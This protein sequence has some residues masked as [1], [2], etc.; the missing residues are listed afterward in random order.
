M[1]ATL[2][3][4]R[5]WIAPLAAA[6]QTRLD[7]VPI[8]GAI[9]GPGWLSLRTGEGFL[10]FCLVRGARWV[11]LSE[12]ALPRAWQELL[13]RHA[14]SP[15]APHL[16]D[17]RITGV[18]PL[19]DPEGS[20]DGL[21]VCI[22]PDR[23]RIRIR[24]FPRPGAL[25]MDQANG[26]ELARFGR[27]E[28]AVLAPL[29]R[30]AKPLDLGQHASTCTA[31]LA[32][33]LLAHTRNRVHQQVQDRSRKLQRLVWTLEGDLE[34]A[35]GELGIRAEADLLA[36]HLHAIRPGLATVEVQDFDGAPRQ[37]ALDPAFPPSVNLARWY[38][39]AAKAERSVAQIEERL[40]KA[41]AELAEASARADELEALATESPEDLDRWVAF[42]SAHG[43]DPRPRDTT[44]SAQKRG[45]DE[46]LPYWVYRCGE[47]EI[48]VGRSAAD[49]DALTLRHSH[50]RDQWLHAQGVPGSHVIVRSAGRP[51]PADIL[52]D[53]A[54]IAAH[55]SKSRTSST[56]A[57]HVA[58][59]R[60]VRKARKAPPGTV[61]LDQAKTLFVSPVIPERWRRDS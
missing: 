48:R 37:L 5:E 39:R 15:F 57:V 35:L 53:A 23:R 41:R 2:P 10:W 30:R 60:H 58:E 24:F 36:A 27:M 22:E 8:Q 33:D 43:I 7:G 16:K 1:Q 34:R 55:F 44:A 19:A 4:P 32:Q 21:E 61:K 6:L 17:G 42:A 51:V 29:A 26:T 12:D 18:R 20:L 46:R 13:G 11:W 45:E 31:L 14:R 38:K 50:L 59:R 52:E 3:A 25:W 40:G 49:N 54:R 28:G 9:A 47:W 56:V